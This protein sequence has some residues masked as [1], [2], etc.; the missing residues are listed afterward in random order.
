LFYN[1]F[2]ILSW[3]YDFAFDHQ[4]D[5][6]YEK[7]VDIPGIK[8]AKLDTFSGTMTFTKAEFWVCNTAKKF[9][10]N[11]GVNRHEIKQKLIRQLSSKAQN[12][13]PWIDNL[14][15]FNLFRSRPVFM[16][17]SHIQVKTMA[18]I[19]LKQGVAL[20]TAAVTDGDLGE[21]T[22]EDVYAKF[23]NDL[24]HSEQANN[25]LD[26]EFDG[27][28]LLQV[29]DEEPPSNDQLAAYVSQNYVPKNTF[30]ELF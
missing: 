4:K 28:N 8:A 23:A 17:P 27:E 15:P 19:L 2:L 21:M 22:L 18:K 10:N 12:I 16:V 1:N 5:N 24:T 29:A 3:S 11:S 20:S 25:I 13:H 30:F 14:T 6:S 7:P 26:F 9:T